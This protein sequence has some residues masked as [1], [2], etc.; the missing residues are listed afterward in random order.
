MNKHFNSAAYELGKADAMLSAVENAIIDLDL[1]PEDREK[2][3]KAAF[4]FYAAWDAVKKA[5]E[6]L[7][8]YSAECRIVDVIKANRESRGV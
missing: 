3:N 7:S 8:E 5:N 4:L 2:M 6:E 1:L